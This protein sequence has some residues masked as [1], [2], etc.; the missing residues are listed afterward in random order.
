M[1]KVSQ[2]NTLIEQP[3]QIKAGQTISFFTA[4]NDHVIGEVLE[5]MNDRMVVL[6][7]EPEMLGSFLFDQIVWPIGHTET[8]VEDVPTD[9]DL[10]V[11][12][13][14]LNDFVLD[15]HGKTTVDTEFARCVMHDYIDRLSHEDLA[16]VLCET[17]GALEAK[18]V[19]GNIVL[20]FTVPHFEVHGDILECVNE[21]DDAVTLCVNANDD[22]ISVDGENVSSPVSLLERLADFLG[23]TVAKKQQ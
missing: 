9:W 19:D 12:T 21:Y 5:V 1:Q 11:N 10:T 7:K 14:C 2:K 13:P 3:N 8:V 18:V 6:T 20:Q 17:Q 16:Q 15:K 23:F 4:N 22:T